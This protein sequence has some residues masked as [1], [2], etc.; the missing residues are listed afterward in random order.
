MAATSSATPFPRW[1]ADR[2]TFDWYAQ[3]KDGNVWYM[4]EDTRELHHGRFVKQS[5]SWEAG[6]DGAEPGIIMPGDPQ[7]GDAYRQEYY[8]GHALDQA[9]VARQ[10]RAGQRPVRLLQ[11]HPGHRGDESASSIPASGSA[12]TT[13]AGSATSRSTR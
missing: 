3:D 5:D 1:E 9:R 11:G 13:S 4:G 6:V 12:S 2:A 7:P 10:R 8:P